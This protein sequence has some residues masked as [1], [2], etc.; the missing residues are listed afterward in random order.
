MV[1]GGEEI[2]ATPEHP[3]YVPKKGWTSAAALRA[4]DQLVALNGELVTVEQVQ[5]ELLETPVKVYNFEVEDFH[6]YFVGDEPVLVHNTCQKARV[7]NV[8]KAESPIWK[9]LTNYKNGIK[10]S[11]SGKNLRYYSWDNFHNEIEV[12]NRFGDHLG[13]M[14]PSTG[15]MI[16]IA[17]KGRKLW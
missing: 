4:G 2:V 13:V 14:D 15:D 10:T 5:H 9:G 12:F 8:S 16:K 6:T 17:V 3:F 7:T 11:G 1:A